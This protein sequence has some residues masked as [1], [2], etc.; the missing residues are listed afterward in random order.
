MPVIE[1]NMVA[2]RSPEHKAALLRGIREAALTSLQVRSEHLSVWGREFSPEDVLLP[3]GT[4]AGWMTICVT[5]FAGRD[6]RT[7]R[8]LYAAMNKALVSAGESPGECQITVL[9]VP[10]E[11]W[12]ISG[13]L[14]AADLF[15]PKDK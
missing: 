2:G 8:Q 7:K 11:S 10:L 4:S 3:A 14:C 9:D 12:G 15:P 13:G 1:I 5:C 6:T